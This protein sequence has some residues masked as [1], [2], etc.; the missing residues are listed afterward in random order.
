MTQEYKQVKVSVPVYI[1]HAFKDTCAA[2]SVSMAS[3]ITKLMADAS[4]V[5][6]ASAKEDPDYSTRRRRRAAIV[7]IVKQLEEIKAYEERYRDN[8]PENLQNS[9]VYEAAEQYIEM[10]D[11]VIDI[12]VPF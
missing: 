12:L 9:V 4:G 6:R 2:R 7:S 1:A 8:I 5:N 3:F 11:E 10:L